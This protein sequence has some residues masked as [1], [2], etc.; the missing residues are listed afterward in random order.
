MKK[1]NITNGDSFNEYFCKKYLSKAL[2]FRENMMDGEAV[3]DIFSDDFIKLRAACHKV[4]ENEYRDK[5]VVFNSLKADGF[6]E[7]ILWFGKDTFCQMNLLTLLAFLEQID[8]RGKVT[9]NLIDDETFEVLEENIDVNLGTYKW[10]YEEIIV[11]KNVVKTEGV[12]DVHAIELF[13]DY[14]SPE[15]TLAK[16]IKNNLHLNESGL[17][18]LLIEKSAE[19]GLSDI[20]AKNLIEKYSK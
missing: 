19:Y 7:I 2:P 14:L 16:L 13:F 4:S 17:I 1:L 11:R 12:L 8:Y 20:Q 18:C 5:S 9:L 6:E 10:Q 3:S 15:G